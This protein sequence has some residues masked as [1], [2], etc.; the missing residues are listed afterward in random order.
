M[1]ALETP[2]AKQLAAQVAGQGLTLEYLDCPKWDRKLPRHLMCVGYF[3]GV[4]AKVKVRLHAEAGGSVTFDAVLQ[5]GV[6]ATRN[7]VE[8]LTTDGYS[9]VDCG[10][11]P[12]YRARVGDKLVC[13]VT[14]SGRSGYVVAT[15]TDKAG[16]VMIKDL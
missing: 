5:Q 14:K 10:D 3:D 11:V 1:D 6:I 15:V 7:L 8:K 9:H 16:G 4:T 2:I 13:A 12:A